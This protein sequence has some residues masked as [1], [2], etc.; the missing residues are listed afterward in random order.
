MGLSCPVRF[1]HDTIKNKTPRATPSI[2]T[3]RT[4][5]GGLRICTS[6][7]YAL[8]HQLS[9]GAESS[10]VK[11]PQ[12]TT[13]A[14]SGARNPHKLTD[15]AR[16][17]TEPKKCVLSASQPQVNPG[18]SPPRYVRMCAG[19]QKVSRPMVECH[20]ISQST[21][22]GMQTAPNISTKQYVGSTLWPPR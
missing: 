15:A 10:I 9:N 21:P 6:S 11:V 8:C 12:I 17:S 3:A 2:P 22:I 1:C 14:P 19:V 16:S 20:E 18:I 4:V 5:C 7:P 13:Q